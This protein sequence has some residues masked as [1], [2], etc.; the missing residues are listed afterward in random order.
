MATILGA[1]MP[2]VREVVTSTVLANAHS[3]AGALASYA[4]S[5]SSV[6]LRTSWIREVGVGDALR[7]RAKFYNR[8]EVKGLVS[9]SNL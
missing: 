8:T 1:S 9:T 3:G 6:V 2:V 5:S 7:R 4:K